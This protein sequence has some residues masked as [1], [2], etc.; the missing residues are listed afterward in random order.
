MALTTTEEMKRGQKKARRQGYGKG[1]Q[2]GTAAALFYA[3]ECFT[4]ALAN[5]YRNLPSETK[6]IN[7]YIDRIL[8]SLETISDGAIQI[9]RDDI[10]RELAAL[11]K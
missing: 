2:D 10:E 5:L 4:G 8:G 3:A 11:K 7:R 1:V 6:E 9:S